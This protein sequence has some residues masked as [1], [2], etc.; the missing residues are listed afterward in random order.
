MVPLRWCS[1]HCCPQS[2]CWILAGPDHRPRVSRL[3]VLLPTPLLPSTTIRL[4]FTSG[5]E[6][7][8]HIIEPEPIGQHRLYLQLADRTLEKITIQACI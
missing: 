4:N 2:G 6:W 8:D 7:G 5:A 3:L 1:G